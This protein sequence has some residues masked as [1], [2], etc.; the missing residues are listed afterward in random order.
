MTWRRILEYATAIVAIAAAFALIVFAI[1]VTNI[2]RHHKQESKKNVTENL[3][4]CSN[5]SETQLLIATTIAM[6]SSVPV[7]IAA[8][9][10]TIAP[11]TSSTTTAAAAATTTTT[12]TTREASDQ[13]QAEPP[14]SIQ[15]NYIATMTNKHEIDSVNN[16]SDDVDDVLIIANTTTTSSTTGTSAS[17]DPVAVETKTNDQKLQQA[18]YGSA[19]QCT[20]ATKSRASLLSI[21]LKMMQ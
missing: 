18:T 7:T 5:C 16:D 9:N 10:T 11:L 15:S 8:I 2:D 1:S 3:I 12:T 4:Q 19:E 20:A 21:I 6:K 14:V 13:I 17:Y